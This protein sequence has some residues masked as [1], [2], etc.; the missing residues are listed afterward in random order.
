MMK[1]KRY[2]LLV[3]FVG[4]FLSSELQAQQKIDGFDYILQK[5]PRLAERDSNFVRQNFFSLGFG[6][7]AIL[8]SGYRESPLWGI[9]GNLSFGRW[10][11]SISGARLSLNGTLFP[12]VLSSESG[13]HN[14][15]RIG[16]NADYLLNL[17]AMGR[18]YDPD[19]FFNFLLLGGIGIHGS[20][21]SDDFRTAFS[22]QGGFQTLFRMCSYASWYIEPR[23]AFYTDDVVLR[24]NWRKY[25]FAPTVTTGIV[26]R[27]VPFSERTYVSRWPDGDFF[28]NTYMMIGGGTEI[29]VSKN[30]NRDLFKKFGYQAR[31]G[32]GKQFTP[33][34][35]LRMTMTGGAAH[36]YNERLASMRFGVDYTVDL[37]ALASGYQPERKFGL[38]FIMGGEV[39]IPEKH[40]NTKCTIGM[41]VGLQGVARLSDRVDL[42][43]EPRINIFDNYFAGGYSDKNIDALGE[44]SAGIIYHRRSKTDRTFRYE[45]A[46]ESL[47]EENRSYRPEN[48]HIFVSI[49]GG[50]QT[51][52]SERVSAKHK[53]QPAVIGSIGYWF[54]TISGVRANGRFGLLG[55][56]NKMGNYVRTKTVSVGADYLFNI[57]NAMNGYL[58][59]RRLEVVGSLGGDVIYNTNLEAGQDRLNF[60]VTAGLEGVWNVT[61]QIALTTGPRFGLYSNDLANSS[62]AYLGGDLVSSWM[63]GITYRF[64]PYNIEG[65]RERFNDGTRNRYFTSFGAGTGT[66]VNS[67]IRSWKYG[68]GVTTAVG[69]WFSPLSA[70]RIGITGEMLPELFHNNSRRYNT[71]AGLDLDYLISLVTL[72]NG[73]KAKRLFDV[74]GV[75]GL[76]VGTTRSNSEFN[77]IPGAHGGLQGTLRLSNSISLYVEPRVSV[78]G[79]KYE[80]FGTKSFDVTLSGKV[81]FIYHFEHLKSY[82]KKELAGKG[83]FVSAGVG[84]GVFGSS[85]L[86]KSFRNK[87]TV[88]YDVTGGKWIT[89]TSGVQVGI[90][91]TDVNYNSNSNQHFDLD[92]IGVHAN[93]LLNITTLLRTRQNVLSLIGIAGLGVDHGSENGYNGW[94]PSV[95]GNLQGLFHVNKHLGIFGEARGII[96]GSNLI[97]NR[98]SV[99]F[100]GSLQFSVGTVWKF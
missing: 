46:V 86:G 64:K 5:R 89:P 9:S 44:L 61:P 100:N 56:N 24:D 69:A 20:M 99:G 76:S 6:S 70:W 59:N 98:P 79:K 73:Y 47:E 36:W 33:V 3:L 53:I 1:E 48:K 25:N 52:F 18:G 38:N 68:V 30:L 66:M 90:Y 43:I 26:Y 31:L 87:L 54:N 51:I 40:P 17:S 55:E 88:N 81:G 8:E 23:L 92:V 39:A 27:M 67:G 10:M 75:I 22:V 74:N 45:S 57:T 60:G 29:L 28:E 83:Y 35:G 13:N 37:D 97:K 50:M 96:Y 77:F 65:N 11:N 49:G 19:R 82:A 78:F 91:K 84:S 80:M 32:I 14:L 85:F 12:K 62:T 7:E 21:M 15:F 16:L 72:A 2:Y 4:L 42:Y 93:Y 94:A 71:Y 34:S 41:G 58:P 95:N 63:V